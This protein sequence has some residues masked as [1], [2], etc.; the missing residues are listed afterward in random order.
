MENDT[1]V[2]SQSD[3][4]RNIISTIEENIDPLTVSSP[5]FSEYLTEKTI[6]NRLSFDT[7][8]AE[9]AN[10]ASFIELPRKNHIQAISELFID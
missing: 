7:A 4:V 9:L 6:Y 5:F 2:L 3:M 8:L 10:Y 1:T